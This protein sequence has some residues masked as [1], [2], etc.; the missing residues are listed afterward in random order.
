M[1]PGHVVAEVGRRSGT[2]RGE[3][4][5]YW[6]AAQGDR[7]EFARD[8]IELSDALPLCSIV[9]RIEGFVDPNAVAH[10]LLRVLESA[11][12]ELVRPDLAERIRGADCLD[13]VL[14]ARRELELESTSS[15]I[16]LPEWFPLRP[17]TSVT[18]T[19]ADLTWSTRVPLSATELRLGELQSLLFDLD[20]ELLR[21]LR[22]SHDRDYRLVNSLHD[23]L[24][25]KLDKP[26]SF[27]ELLSRAETKLDRIQN[28]R[29]Y[30]P[31]AAH[32]PTIM[33]HLWRLANATSTDGLVKL[34]KVV[35][36]ALDISPAAV[37][38]RHE[39]IVT[40]LNRPKDLS[41]D[42]LERWGFNLIVTIRGACQLATAAAHADEYAEYSLPLVRSL[43]RDLR[44]SID[45]SVNALA[46]LRR[47]RSAG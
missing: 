7:D 2:R 41:S 25:P 3:L 28:P 29:D 32:N 27:D 14:I 20:R 4:C 19:I 38:N 46:S 8:L 35:V 22:T 10:D 40:I 37:E 45:E 15:P 6:I 31:S 11:K 23:R 47:V 12:A 36:K 44:I 18:A 5:F 1:R 24:K 42:P 43:S 34:A 16:A 33:G 13:V 39:S 21:N 26:I 9:V 17:A 30:R